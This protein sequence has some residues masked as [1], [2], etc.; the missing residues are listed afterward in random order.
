MFLAVLAGTKR[1]FVYKL[2]RHTGEVNSD[3]QVNA[4]CSD[5]HH[6]LLVCKVGRCLTLA[7]E[8]V[9]EFRCCEGSLPARAVHLACARVPL[10]RQKRELVGQMKNLFVKMTFVSR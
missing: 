1:G 4:D 5:F 2:P 8:E 3:V 9:E 10:G 6:L 7:A